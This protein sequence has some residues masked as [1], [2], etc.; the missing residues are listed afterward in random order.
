MAKEKARKRIRQRVANANIYIKSGFNNTLLTVTTEE[1][2]V[3]ARSSAGGCGFKGTKKSTP[4]AAQ[5]AAEKLVEKVVPYGIEKIDVY[6]KGVGPGREQSIRG[7][8][9]GDFKIGRIM[10]ITPIPHNGCRKKRPRRV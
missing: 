7:L 9:S 2:K 5:V 6:V 8:V 3:L 4:Y 10:D 1:G